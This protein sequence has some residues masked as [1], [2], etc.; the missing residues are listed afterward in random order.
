M[1]L[2]HGLFC[3]FLSTITLVYTNT[4]GW[5]AEITGLAYLGID[6]GFFIGLAAVGTTT[7]KVIIALTKKN[8][9]VYE[10]E[11]RLLYTIFFAFL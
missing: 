10:P 6:L 5:S 8:N 9:G 7:D 1:A 4:Y 3:S 11:M 2:V